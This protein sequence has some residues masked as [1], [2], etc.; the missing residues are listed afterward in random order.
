MDAAV[1]ANPWMDPLA[2]APVG[3]GFWAA[4]SQ[5]SDRSYI[6]VLV[7]IALECVPFLNMITRWISTGVSM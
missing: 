5:Q 6:L 7:K 2:L 1:Q 3:S 4:N